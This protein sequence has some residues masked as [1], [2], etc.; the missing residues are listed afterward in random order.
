MGQAKLRGSRKDR[1]RT[2]SKKWAKMK[3]EAKTAAMFK[4]QNKIENEKDM[5]RLLSLMQKNRKDRMNE[6]KHKQNTA[7]NCCH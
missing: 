1:V 7:Y 4:R 5:K 3:L 6:W 2:A